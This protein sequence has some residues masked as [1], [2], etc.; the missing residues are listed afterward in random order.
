MSPSSITV[1][2]SLLLF[3]TYAQAHWANW[4]LDEG[5][6]RD[7]SAWKSTASYNH[8]MWHECL[9]ETASSANIQQIHLDTVTRWSGDTAAYRISTTGACTTRRLHIRIQID[10]LNG[11]TH[12]ADNVFDD[13]YDVHTSETTDFCHDAKV[14][15]K[16]I[17][18]SCHSGLHHFRLDD[19]GFPPASAGLVDNLLCTS[20]TSN[21]DRYSV[22]NTTSTVKSTDKLFDISV[23]DT[24]DN[25][26]IVYYR[27]SDIN[28]IYW[29]TFFPAAVCT[30]TGATSS[31]LLTSHGDF[32]TATAKF[33]H[34]TYF[35]DS[36]RG[37]VLHT[38]LKL[39]TTSVL[40]NVNL[41]SLVKT[42]H[43]APTLTHSSTTGVHALYSQSLPGGVFT[44]PYNINR[45]FIA[46]VGVVDDGGGTVLV[47]KPDRLSVQ[48][49]SCFN[50][51][52]V[53]GDKGTFVLTIP[54]NVRAYWFTKRVHVTTRDCVNFFVLSRPEDNEGAALIWAIKLDR[55]LQALLDHTYT[56]P[57]LVSR[58]TKL[59][60][61]GLRSHSIQIHDIE[62][63]DDNS[64][65]LVTGVG[66]ERF[67]I[68]VETNP[69]ESKYGQRVRVSVMVVFALD[70]LF[71]GLMHGMEPLMTHLK[72]SV[73]VSSSKSSRRK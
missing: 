54:S 19:S 6:R 22:L 46:V 29:A 47:G 39:D 58:G 50:H 55:G 43:E 8:S 10:V 69:P 66:T 9:N 53:G 31:P 71:I 17:I 40:S 49:T 45:T 60:D 63:H 34:I 16:S 32:G 12:E 1:V 24:D 27:Q 51:D 11:A 28:R 14:T 64:L 73:G 13:S 36:V 30:E 62:Q 56:P 38:A 57:R 4:F 33:E 72:S 48:Y 35:G 65:T 23:H 3:T 41:L 70:I 5:W 68:N 20:S 37:K 18:I 2:V 26:T 44:C 61:D 52:C 21:N 42:T 59:V 25:A 7:R 67:H 15:R